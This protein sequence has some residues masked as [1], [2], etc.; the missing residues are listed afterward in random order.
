MNE[1]RP[2]VLQ[3][4]CCM[5]D[6]A[7]GRDAGLAAPA[8]T[9][10]AIP[11]NMASGL[12]I[13][14]FLSAVAVVNYHF[15]CLAARE[16]IWPTGLRAAM[17]VAPDF[18]ELAPI[19][20][21]GWV[22]VEIF[23]V[24]SGIVI[25]YSAWGTDARGFL[26]SRILRLA[27][28]LW[29]FATLTL[30]VTFLYSPLG[31]KEIGVLYI[32]S[33]LLTPIGPWLDGVYW[34]LV[35]EAAFYALIW[36]FLYANRVARLREF[37]HLWASITTLLAVATLVGHLAGGP[38]Y[39]IKIRESYWG[40]ILLLTTGPYFILGMALY[41]V[42]RDG[43]RKDHLALLA[44]SFI[45]SEIH[46]YIFAD[47]HAGT[48]GMPGGPLVPCAVFALAVACAALSLVMSG[49]R[50]KKG[51]G[52]RLR[53]LRVLGMATY[54]LYLLHGITGAWVLGRMLEAGVNRFLSLGL[55]VVLCIGASLAFA[56]YLEGRLRRAVGACYDTLVQRHARA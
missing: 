30:L 21:F 35:V 46:I 53:I 44:A 20:W 56:G 22:G 26:R 10:R 38:E 1:G 7:A 54:P 23:F 51:C 13:I 9:D 14:R 37:T 45:A 49:G 50:Q 8:E 43:P 40:R 33:I 25:T 27:P 19:F 36:M 2:S 28:A 41:F 29:F 5:Q 32:K 52:R 12:E 42:M 6:Q 4:H 39:L 48:R 34:T 18:G 17:G 11:R 55:A 3:P 47:G 24:V 15:T 16:P 31:A